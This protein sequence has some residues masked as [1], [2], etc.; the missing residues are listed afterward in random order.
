MIAVAT[1]AFVIFREGFEAILLIMLMGS[2]VRGKQLDWKTLL[3]GLS[4][5][6]LGSTALALLIHEWAEEHHWFE[7]VI[8]LTAAAVL[9][10]V[11][12][13]NRH[14]QTHIKDHLD[15]VRG[16]GVWLGM[17]T[18]GLIFLREGA[19]IVL[20]LASVWREDM[21]GTVIGGTLGAAA[22]T[23]IA[24]LFLTKIMAKLELQRV[25]R[26]SNAALAVLALWFLAQGTADLLH[27]I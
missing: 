23:M 15:E 9:I 13:W 12:M 11:V 19:E 7:A 18:V 14:V 5:G 4:A 24:W 21:S 8:N 10:Y 16:S 3:V 26:W 25:F 20:M 2:M 22:L 1:S 27:L 17:L 6:I